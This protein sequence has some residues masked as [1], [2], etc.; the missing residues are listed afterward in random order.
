MNYMGTMKL[1]EQEKQM[2]GFGRNTANGYYQGN[3][4]GIRTYMKDNEIILEIR[5]LYNAKA[6]RFLAEFN[7]TQV[8]KTTSEADSLMSIRVNSFMKRL[9]KLGINK[10]DIYIDMIYLV[11]TFEFEVTNKIFSKTYNEKPTGFEMQK[12]VHIKFTDINI[13]DELVTSAAKSEIY[14]MVK[15]DFF[16]DNTQGIYD[17]LR[18]QSVK[19]VNKKLASFKKLNIDM[20]GKYQVVREA[21]R[22]IYPESQ[23]SNYDAFVTQSLEAAKGKKEVTRVRKPKTVAYDQIPYSEFDIVMYP[24]ILE[25][26]VQ[27]VYTL[28]CKYTLPQANKDDKPNYMLVTPNGDL[29]QLPK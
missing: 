2:D 5:S 12:N 28:Q 6:D 19:L 3:T 29:K 9:Q 21:A 15:L 25:P 16:V 26:V 23:Y 8:G 11:P 13:I 20:T 18:D 7:L 24:D 27:Y 14:D 17:T 1:L 10:D 4:G 22:T